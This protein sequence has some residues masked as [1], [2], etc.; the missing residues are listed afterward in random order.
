MSITLY[1]IQNCATMKKARVWL[2]PRGIAYH[3]HDYKAV[4]IGK[5]HLALVQARSAGDGAQSCRHH[6]PRPA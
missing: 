6:L 3:F 4:G 5:A 1:G 2:D